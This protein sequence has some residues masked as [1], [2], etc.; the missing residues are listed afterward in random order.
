MKIGR[1]LISFGRIDG[2][3]AIQMKTRCLMLEALLLYMF[4]EY[5]PIRWRIV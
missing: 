3:L 2:G 5:G 4:L 1:S